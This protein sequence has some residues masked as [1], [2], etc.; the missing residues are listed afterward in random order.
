M[1]IDGVIDKYLEIMRFLRSHK[2]QIFTK[3][4][5]TTFQDGSENYTMLMVS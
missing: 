4:R 2:F 3:P 5:D 1:S